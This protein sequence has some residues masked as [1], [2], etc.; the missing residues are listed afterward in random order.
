M[1]RVKLWVLELFTI[2]LALLVSVP[3]YLVII[4][5]FK[6]H[7]EIVTKPLAF[8]NLSVGLDNVIR[9]FQKMDIIRAYKTNISIEVIAVFVGI[10]FSAL[11][12]YAVSRINHRFNHSMY[13]VFLS[14]IMIPIQSAFIPLVFILKG[15]GLNNSI[16]GIALVYS[17]VISPF[18]IFV[19]SG[20]MRTIP[21]DLEESAFID[22]C[23]P[24]RAFFQIIF[25]LIKPVTATLIILQF[26]YVWNDLLLPLVLLSSSDFPTVSIALYKFFGAR[27]TADLSLLFGGISLALFPVLVLF[28]SFQRYFVKGLVTGAVKG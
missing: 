16:L 1:K 11:A 12:G 24:T 4:N 6:S 14:G 27:G 28:F 19:F 23:S 9:A 3:L 10:L 18:A 25:P 13:W 20:L 22:G 15:I 17:A 2:F 26:I 5:T 8:P 21:M 7:Q